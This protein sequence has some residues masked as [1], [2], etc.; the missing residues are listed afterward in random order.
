MRKITKE[1]IHAFNNNLYFKKSNSEVRILALENNIPCH[2][3]LFL[4]GNMIAE[5]H[6]N[7][8]VNKLRISTCGW[9]TS[10][11]KERLNALEGVS[12]TQKNFVLYLNGKEWNGK[13][14][15]IN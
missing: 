3:G 12:I 7:K 10:T 11:T 15:D 4:H 8:R 6:T 13:L 1:T 2:I 9:N 14:I 5:K